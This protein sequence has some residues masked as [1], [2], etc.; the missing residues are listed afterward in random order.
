M[1]PQVNTIFTIFDHVYLQAT[2]GAELMKKKSPMKDYILGSEEYIISAEDHIK[3]IIR[4]YGITKPECHEE[5]EQ[6]IRDDTAASIESQLLFNH[7][8]NG[9][10]SL[11][12]L[13]IIIRR[14]EDLHNKILKA[15][16]MH[17]AQRLQN[18]SKTIFRLKTELKE[19]REQP[20]KEQLVA[21][22]EQLQKELLNDI[23]A[24][25]QASHTRI[26]NFYL[27]GNGTMAPQSFYIVKEKQGNRTIRSLEVNDEEITEPSE[28]IRVMQ[29][30]YEKTAQE[31]TAQT[32]TL[33]EFL[34][35]HGIQLPQL[36]D[37]QAEELEQEFSQHE[38]K[39]ALSE[40]EET[41]APGPSGHSITFYKLLF[42]ETP[43]LFTEAL[44]QLV[45][46]PGISNMKGVEWIHN[47]K[48]IYI[49]KK[50]KPVTPS[51]YRPLSLLE[52]LYKIPSRILSKRITRVLP[53]IIGS[54]QHGFMA[55]KGIQEP[56][57]LVT[58]LI[59]DAN[60]HDNPLQLISFD[61]EKAFDKVSHQVILQ[62]LTEFGFPIIYIEAIKEYILT[63]LQVDGS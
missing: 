58:N 47:R 4:Q 21:E 51:D 52:V 34:I 3:R 35:Q 1:K 24:K 11:L 46:V 28:I 23:E 13:N 50:S 33:R 16:K 43:K 40:A 5:A 55:Q 26:K 25:E 8:S 22:I 56:S 59:H 39:D 41:S 60:K 30:W 18:T 61:I 2:F 14:L 19:T 38:V 10:N 20:V 44:N 54:H 62:A 29:D 57:T 49:P 7:D 31:E 9:I 63:N 53:T 42:L 17:S 12:V 32:T 27:S 37:N 45:F 48:I 15:S 6:Q 36:S